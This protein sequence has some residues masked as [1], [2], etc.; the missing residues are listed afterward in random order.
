MPTAYKFDS[1]LKKII[2]IARKYSKEVDFEKEELIWYNIL[3]TI[4][5]LKNKR[6][7]AKKWFCKLFF[8]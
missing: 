5:D 6:Q 1:V 7:L 2:A 4:V 3:D 8:T